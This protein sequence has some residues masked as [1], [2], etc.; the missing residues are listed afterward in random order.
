MVGV[1]SMQLGTVA[2]LMT[3]QPAGGPAMT[4]AAAVVS[5]SMY[6]LVV[7]TGVGQPLAALQLYLLSNAVRPTSTGCSVGTGHSAAS[8]GGDPATQPVVWAGWNA[9]PKLPLVSAQ[10]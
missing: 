1:W 8:V 2:V 3:V 10:L 4:V 5:W 7:P 9:V 6:A